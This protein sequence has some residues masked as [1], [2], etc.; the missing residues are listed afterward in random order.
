MSADAFGRASAD[1]PKA[2]LDALIGA[3]S[4]VYFQS[5]QN[6][7]SGLEFSNVLVVGNQD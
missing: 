2:D 6:P 4:T 5:A 7:G 1:F 3:G